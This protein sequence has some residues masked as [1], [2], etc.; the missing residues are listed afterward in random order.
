MSGRYSDVDYHH[1]TKTSVVF[2]VVLFV[3]AA[4]GEFAGT[5]LFGGLVGWEL[6][7]LSNVELAGVGIAFAAPF[8]F[9]I[10]LPLIVS[11]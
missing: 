10:V 11:E 7:L 3:A 5:T 8:L 2:G 6:A 1:L 4:V 9:G